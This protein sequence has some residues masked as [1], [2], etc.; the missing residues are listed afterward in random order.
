MRLEASVGEV[1]MY[2][3]NFARIFYKYLQIYLHQVESFQQAF[4]ANNALFNSNIV[5]T[6]P[7]SR[8]VQMVQ[9]KWRKKKFK[10]FLLRI[11]TEIFLPLLLNSAEY[12]CTCRELVITY[13]VHNIHASF[14]L[15]V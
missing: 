10:K 2:G 9:G 6:S 4:H 1:M 11:G 8:L 3:L 14:R 7:A 13:S 15:I 5:P 12:P